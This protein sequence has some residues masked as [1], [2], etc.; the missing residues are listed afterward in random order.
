MYGGVVTQ[1]GVDARE[2]LASAVLAKRGGVKADASLKLLAYAD[3]GGR[4]VPPTPVEVLKQRRM[5]FSK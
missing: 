5:P 4:D 1:Y 3:D 2:H